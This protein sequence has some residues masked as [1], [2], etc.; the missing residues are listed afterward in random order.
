MA[1]KETDE[2]TSYPTTFLEKAGTQTK[3]ALGVALK[4]GGVLEQFLPMNGQLATTNKATFYTMASKLRIS[5]YHNLGRN[6]DN[7]RRWL[8]LHGPILTRFMVDRTW[9]RATETGGQLDI[10]LPE[11]A[12][13]GH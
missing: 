9:D 6:Q 1:N 5:S 3:L 7:W 10:Y 2:I 12:R 4:Y 13:G 11:T 8:A